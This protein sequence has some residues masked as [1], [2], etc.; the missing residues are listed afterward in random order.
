MFGRRRP[1]QEIP[2]CLFCGKTQDQVDALISN[3]SERSSRVCIC[4]ECVAVCNTVLAEHRKAKAATLEAR[5][6]AAVLEEHKNAQEAGATVVGRLKAF[7]G[8]P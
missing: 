5:L 3:P 4:N 2:R 1:Q 7:A 6:K 8:R